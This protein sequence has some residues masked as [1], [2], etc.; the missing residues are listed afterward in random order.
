MAQESEGETVYNSFLS[1][2]ANETL[3]SHQQF[4]SIAHV[5]ETASL[6]IHL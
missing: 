5:C 1:A 2:K 4:G 6:I 3:F